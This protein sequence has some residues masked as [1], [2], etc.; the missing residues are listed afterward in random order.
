MIKAGNGLR[1]LRERKLLTQE[2]LAGAIGARQASVSAWER[3]SARPSNASKRKLC[4]VLG[5]TI[6]ELLTALEETDSEGKGL[7][8]A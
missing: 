4:D 5:V 6:D 1:R 7:A 3:G 2:E 8:A